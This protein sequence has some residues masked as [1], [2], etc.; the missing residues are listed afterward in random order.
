MKRHEIEAAPRLHWLA[1][2]ESARIRASRRLDVDRTG[3]DFSKLQP[4]APMPKR[5]PMPS[6]NEK[7]G[8]HH[9][10]AIALL[11]SDHDT[12]RDLLSQLEETTERGA[13]K[14]TELVARIA[15]EVRI[16]ARIE[17]EIFYPAY[18]EAARAKEDL[19]LFFEAAEE[20][21]LVDVVL[22]ALEEGDPAT[23]EFGAKCKVLKDLIEH[24]A[25]EE[26]DEMFPRARKLL[27][28]E[29]LVELGEQMAARKEELK[30]E[31]KA[32]AR[33]KAMRG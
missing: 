27:G 26:E 24:H 6:K 28:K 10:D 17:E 30:S 25:Q 32:P 3:D 23:A 11:Q 13:K 20:H 31:M 16:H 15:T 8:K 9:K 7:N 18:K 22:P 2:P 12:V 33:Q 1:L 19:K 14:R 5:E 21:A 4:A 29:R